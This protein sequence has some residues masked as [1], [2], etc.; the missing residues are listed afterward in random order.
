MEQVGGLMATMETDLYYRCYHCGGLQV[1]AFHWAGDPLYFFHQM[2][3]RDGIE[4]LE[5]G[6]MDE[7][8]YIEARQRRQEW[9]RN[10]RGRELHPALE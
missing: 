9:E 4:T 5:S 7:A 2:F 3:M 8:D 1:P 6:E 10:G